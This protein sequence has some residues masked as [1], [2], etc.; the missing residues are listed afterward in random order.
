[1]TGKIFAVDFDGTLCE[2]RYPEIG[3]PIDRVIRYVK[4]VQAAGN[5]LILHTCRRARRLTAAVKW[6]AD[7]GIKFDY[8]NENVPENVKRYGGDTRKIYA[9]VYI[10]T[11]AVNPL[12]NL[13]HGYDDSVEYGTTAGVLARRELCEGGKCPCPNYRGDSVD[14]C[15]CE[16]F[17]ALREYFLLQILP[18]D[19]GAGK[20]E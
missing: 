6:C 10:D 14:A 1:M 2:D 5:V 9:D 15:S 18:A 8:I 11:A 13:R 3:N 7:H 20:E 4:Q 17:R 16:V 12:G 19:D